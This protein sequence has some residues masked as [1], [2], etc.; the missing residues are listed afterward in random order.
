MS[1][2]SSSFI[3]CAIRVDVNFIPYSI[4][5]SLVI[6][7]TVYLC[8]METMSSEK[9]KTLTVDNRFKFR[10]HKTL[11]ND[12]QCWKCY[13]NSCKGVLKVSLGFEVLEKLNEHIHEKCGNAFSVRPKINNLVKRKAANG[14]LEQLSKII[15]AVLKNVDIPTLEPRGLK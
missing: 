6:I 8:R 2:C 4:S 9:G 1:W 5:I 11:Q 3:H 13:P 12:V 15:R 14:I 10:L 7:C